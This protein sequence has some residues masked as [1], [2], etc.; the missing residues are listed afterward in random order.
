VTAAETRP[1]AGRKPRQQRDRAAS[2]PASVM[3]DRPPLRA[4][5]LVTGAGTGPGNNVIRSL[6]AGARGVTVIGCHDE[7]FALKKSLARRDYLVPRP[8]DAAY[9]PSIRR[10][11]EAERIDL[12][13]P[14]SDAVATA[15]S[16]ARRR[17]GT[18][19]FLPR[20][21]VLDRCADKYAVSAHL[22][23]RGMPAPLTVW[24]RELGAIDE[25]FERFP[26][27]APLWCRTRR[28]SGALGATAV[29]T[30][31]QA[32]TWIKLWHE[33]RGLPVGQF[34]LSE[35]LPG[36]DFGC[37]SLWKDGELIVI[38][39]FERVA[40]FAGGSYL[41]GV[42]SV[43]SLAK[44]VRE[45]RVAEVC[46]AAVRALDPRVS[47][48][49]QVDS[50]QDAAGTPCVTEVNAGRF[51]LSTHLFDL[52]GK[53]NMAVLYVRVALGEAVNVRDE[54]DVAEDYYM[55]RDLDTLPDV[56]HASELFAGIADAR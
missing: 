5:L 33:R 22:R 37:Q 25:L 8:D 49:F 20:Q 9:A 31:E 3:A 41:S 16:R 40:Y 13:V 52:I 56:F 45:P 26:R 48:L 29:D 30:P 36:R 39:T 6:Q 11:V 51:G 27:G 32:R 34:T 28:G 7:R 18:R 46:A 12:L 53:R 50:K 54:Y 10:I 19:V 42:S 4:R 1:V 15:V 17:L 2:G 43:A 47:G 23:A 14:T 35:Y 44:S 21:A 38:K 24:V 55:V